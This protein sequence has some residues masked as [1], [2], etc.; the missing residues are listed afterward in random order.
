MISLVLDE[1]VFAE[2][3][4]MFAPQTPAVFLPESDINVLRII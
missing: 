1:L 2:T 4:K 3:L